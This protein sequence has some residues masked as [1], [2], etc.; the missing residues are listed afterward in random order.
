[1]SVLMPVMNSSAVCTHWAASSGGDFDKLLVVCFLPRFEYAVEHSEVF[2][3]QSAGVN[4]D[5]VKD[6]DD[7]GMPGCGVL[8]VLMKEE[9]KDAIE[10]GVI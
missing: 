1:M 9:R 4:E 10:H 8:N 7:P 5:L 2:P 6:R 3:P